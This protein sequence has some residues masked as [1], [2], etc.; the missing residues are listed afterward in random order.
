MPVDPSINRSI[1]YTIVFSNNTA[2]VVVATLAMP[3]DTWE[4]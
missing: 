1:L 4:Y 2:I 3:A